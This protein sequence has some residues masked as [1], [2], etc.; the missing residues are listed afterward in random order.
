MRDVLGDDAFSKIKARFV[1]EVEELH[2]WLGEVPMPALHEITVRCHKI[3]GGAAVLGASDYRVRLN[4]IE[5]A[6]KAK[7][8]NLVAAGIAS[9]P[10]VWEE[11]KRAL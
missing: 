6:A 7:D 8:A 10:R 2:Q 1:A 9:L 3:A 5:D 11:T 4:A